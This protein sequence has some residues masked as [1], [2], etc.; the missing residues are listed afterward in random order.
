MF[1]FFRRNPNDRDA[2]ASELTSWPQYNSKAQQ[3]IRFTSNL[4]SFPIECRYAASRVHF[5]NEY[6]PTIE[7]N[8]DKECNTCFSQSA[9]AGYIVSS[10]GALICIIAFCFRGFTQ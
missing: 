3:Y 7:Q 5:W 2:A 9:S 1:V 4:T 6:V 8:C 10:V